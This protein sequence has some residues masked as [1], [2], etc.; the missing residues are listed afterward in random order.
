MSK[1]KLSKAE[2]LM[3]QESL[4]DL[5]AKVDNEVAHWVGAP[6]EFTKSRNYIYTAEGAYEVQVR[7]FAEFTSK[8]TEVPGGMHRQ[9]QEGIQFKAGRLP[10]SFLIRARN[11]FRLAFNTKQTEALYIVMFD[12]QTNEYIEYIPRQYTGGTHAEEIDSRERPSGT[13]LVAHIHSHPNFTGRFSGIDNNDDIK[14]SDAAIFGVLGH[15]NRDWPEMEWRIS[16]G[17]RYVPISD[18]MDIFTSPLDLTEPVAD[19]PRE[20]LERIVEKPVEED[21]VKSWAN[22]SYHGYGPRNYRCPWESDNDF[23]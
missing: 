13:V 19:I 5:Q 18:I 21:S 4:A 11:W 14:C 6:A 10:F 3:N 9:I 8:L 1:K 22:H 2:K 20:W 17:K 16:A 15:V 7:P 23:F 12:L